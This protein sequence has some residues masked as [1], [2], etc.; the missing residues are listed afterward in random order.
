M[1]KRLL[2]STISVGRD[3]IKR[4][5]RD[6]IAR[7]ATFGTSILRP[8]DLLVV[9]ESDA[10]TKAPPPQFL[11]SDEQLETRLRQPV[12]TMYPDMKAGFYASTYG[13]FPFVFGA[14]PSE[15]FH[16]FRMAATVEADC[17]PN[18]RNNIG[19]NCVWTSK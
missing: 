9:R 13:A 6:Q 3:Q 7:Q 18:D 4:Q 16:L 11:A 10:N 15:R 2:L 17:N 14:V 8:G 1:V 5:L 12:A 19:R